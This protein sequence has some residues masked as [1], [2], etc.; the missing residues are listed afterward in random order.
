MFSQGSHVPS[1]LVGSR[2]WEAFR[3]SFKWKL[4]SSLF[5]HMISVRT[6]F[7]FCICLIF[8]FAY[9]VYYCFCEILFLISHLSKGIFLLLVLHV[10]LLRLLSFIFQN[11]INSSVFEL[12]FLRLNDFL[13][14]AY[15]S[16]KFVFQIR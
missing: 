1:N 10:W 8:R 15:N 11:L 5:F 13:W 6:C 2:E 14:F 9:L 16:S 7:C 4:C 3:K 12:R